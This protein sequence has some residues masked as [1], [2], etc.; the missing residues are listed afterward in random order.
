MRVGFLA[1]QAPDISP[2]QRYRVE[3]FQPWLAANGVEWDSLWVLDRSGLDIFYKATTLQE[4]MRVAMSAMA[5][6]LRSVTITSLCRRYDVF[7]VQR[8]AFFLLGGW[9]EW[10]AHL[11][12]PVIYDF[13]DAIWIHAI[14]DANRRFSFLKNVEKIPEIIRLSHTV[15]AGNEYLASYARK[16]NSHVQV[17]PTCV[18][19]DR[20]VPKLRPNDGTVVIGWSGSPSTVA[21]LKL[22]LPALERIKQRYGPRVRFK[23]V[24]D[25][26]FRHEGLNIVGEAWRSDMEVFALQG[27]DIGLMPLPDE[28]WS[29]GKCGLKGLT[30]MAVGVPSVM[31]AVG[32]NTEIVQDGINGFTPRTEDEWVE[33]LSQLV[34]DRELR[35]TLGDAGRHTVVERYSVHRWRDTLLSVVRSAAERRPR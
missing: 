19:T 30:Y 34:E 18:D 21:H 7:F 12:A 25:P 6:R 28:E 5:R 23:V 15:L 29:K 10:F 17:V 9:S 33:R 26:N 22:A 3:A 4:K 32:V 2:S 1:L 8:E 20:Y 11:Q 13:D 24:G 14:S 16:F 31:A 27:M 35:R